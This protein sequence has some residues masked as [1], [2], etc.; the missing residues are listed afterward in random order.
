MID[1]FASVKYYE[2]D[3]DWFF[4][5]SKGPTLPYSKVGP[6]KLSMQNFFP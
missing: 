3:T 6:L 1:G 4:G 2:G 5:S